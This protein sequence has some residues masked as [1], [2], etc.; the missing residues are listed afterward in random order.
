MDLFKEE[1]AKSYVK[2]LATVYIELFAYY[3]GIVYAPIMTMYFNKLWYILPFLFI[4]MIFGTRMLYKGLIISSKTFEIV[5]VLFATMITLS[6][7]VISHYKVFMTYMLD[8]TL[9][10][11]AI[12]YTCIAFTTLTL[13]VL[14]TPKLNYMFLG[15][16]LLFAL[17]LLCGISLIN[18]IFTQNYS[19]FIF[20]AYLGVTIFML[21]IIYDTHNILKNVDLDD[22][23]YAIKSVNI[24][25]DIINLFSD[26]LTIL[27]DRRHK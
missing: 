6:L 21:Y 22:P 17:N 2:Y 10:P 24:A 1:F 4:F 14:F 19:I 25:L 15:A 13:L 23:N 8:A 16:P 12:L 7:G 3:I 9:V 11:T 26:I 20:E 18:Y 5:S 27:K